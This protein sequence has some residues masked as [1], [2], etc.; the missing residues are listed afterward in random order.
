M[1]EYLLLLIFVLIAEYF[2]IKYD[3]G[4][5]CKWDEDRAKVV[6][7]IFHFKKDEEVEK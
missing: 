5:H 4:G 3:L 1:K 2:A 6:R 7:A